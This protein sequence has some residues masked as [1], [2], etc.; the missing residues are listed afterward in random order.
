MFLG[1]DWIHR[2]VRDIGEVD[3]LV[4]RLYARPPVSRDGG[5]NFCFEPLTDP[6]R[7][8]SPATETVP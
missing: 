2:R 1:I 4:Y 7:V 5:E 6:L 8:V 3:V